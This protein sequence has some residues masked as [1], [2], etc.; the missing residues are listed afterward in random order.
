MI[1]LRFYD[2]ERRTVAVKEIEWNPKT[3]SVW[4]ACEKWDKAIAEGM[5]T[6]GAWGF[7]EM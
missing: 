1:K 7:E 6:P 5:E 4:E 2:K 3:E